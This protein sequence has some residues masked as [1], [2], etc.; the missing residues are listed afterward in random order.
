MLKSELHTTMLKG[1]AMRSTRTP[2]AASRSPLWAG[3]TAALLLLSIGGCPMDAVEQGAPGP[4]GA[5]GLD[6]PQGPQ[7]PAGQPGAQGP[8]GPQGDPGPQGPQGDP[9]AQGPQGDP[10]PAGPP[11]A[12]GQLRIFGDGSAGPL[13][14]TSNTDLTTAAPASNNFQFTDFT[15]DAGVQLLVPS[16][17]TI[18]CTGTFTNNGV[19]IVFPGANGAKADFDAADSTVFSYSPPGAGIALSPPGFG[20]VSFQ[21]AGTL[22]SGEGGQG[23]PPLAALFMLDPGPHGGG[24]GAASPNGSSNAFGGDG[25]GSFVVLCQGAVLN[26]GV[27][28]ANGTSDDAGGGAGGI[29][30]LASRTSVE[31]SGA[32]EANGAAGG[33]SDDGVG[34]SGG[35]GGGIIHL[36]A[37][38]ITNTGTATVD[39]GAAGTSGA[40]GSIVNSRRAGGAGGGAC[41]GSGG[42]GGEAAGADPDLAEAGEP[43]HLLETPVDPTALF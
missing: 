4:A 6:G 2:F 28:Q 30:I 18:R 40:A 34:A 7:G 8:A 37:P 31:N 21:A 42:D 3:V 24:G 29:V 20:E 26:T 39:G 36:L 27:I 19:I 1:N 38:F 25:G 43:G 15:V 5:Q 16:G 11:G 33:A 17:V 23:I 22:E 14:I 41:G 12:D 10:G 35:G 32:I 9:G 13:A